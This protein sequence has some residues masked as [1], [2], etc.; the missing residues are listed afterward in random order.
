MSVKFGTIY[1]GKLG[2]APNRHAASAA[3]ARPIYHDRVQA[4]E[5]FIL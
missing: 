5:V 3:H 1:T 2:F 4:D